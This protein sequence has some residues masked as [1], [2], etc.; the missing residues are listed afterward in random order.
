[1]RM[2]FTKFSRLRLPL[3]VNLAI[4]MIWFFNA[5]FNMYFTYACSMIALPVVIMACEVYKLNH[6]TWFVGKEEVFKR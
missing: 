6:K 4:F 3:T 2:I 5:M 1:M